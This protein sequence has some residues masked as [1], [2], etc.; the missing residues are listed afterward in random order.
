MFKRIFSVAPL[1]ALTLMI[2]A[3]VWGQTHNKRKRPEASPPP[4]TLPYLPGEARFTI[5]GEQNPVIRLAMAASGVTVVE[6][7]AADKFFAVHPPRNGDWVEVEKSPSLKSD[8]HLVLR[9]GKDLL[10]APG[11]AASISVQMRSGLVVTLWIYPV[12]FI[13]QQTHRCVI[14]YNRDEIVEARRRAG[15]AVNLGED[16]EHEVA[17]PVL[18]DTVAAKP[19]TVSEPTPAASTPAPEV[20]NGEHSKEPLAMPPGPTSIKETQPEQTVK[21]LRDLLRKA[22]AE[23]KEFKKW[24]E[25]TNGLSVATRV[26]DLDASVRVAL[27][28]V[29]NHQTDEAIRL[30]DGHPDLVVQT[31]DGKSKI[32]QLER[33]KQ[34]HAAS[35]TTNNIIPA[36]ATVYF[37]VA[38]A[39]PVL[40]KQQR[41][42]VTVG[43]KNAADDPAIAGLSTKK[44]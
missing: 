7:P 33:V 41:L 3:G 42:T 27:V 39:P 15:L 31:L 38:F 40:G 1:I 28:A 9:A 32:I 6:F 16:A 17:K 35:T 18:A 22:A 23:P 5:K 2:N 44:K 24:T 43:Q 11:P 13:S 26:R 19:P 12:K 30:L 4:Q 25:K 34:L 36:N 20:Q 29:R 21:A 10:N 14:S 37:A 8:T